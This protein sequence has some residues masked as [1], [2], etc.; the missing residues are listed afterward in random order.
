MPQETTPSWQD[1]EEIGA[2]DGV[3]TECE[4][5]GKPGT[6]RQQFMHMGVSICYLCADERADELRMK[7]V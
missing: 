1:L 6:P 4:R 2:D 5:S 7:G 3:P